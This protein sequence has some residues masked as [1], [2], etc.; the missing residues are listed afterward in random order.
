[1]SVDRDREVGR[2]QVKA[3][4]P[5]LLLD[6]ATRQLVELGLDLIAEVSAQYGT[7]EHPR[8][9]SGTYETQVLMTYHNGGQDGHTSVGEQGCGVPRN[10][11]RLAGAVNAAAKA[12]VISPLVRAIAFYA[13][14]AHDVR[15]L[16]G[17]LLLPEGQQ[18]SDRGDER[19]SALQAQ[20]HL[21]QA[22]VDQRWVDLAQV[23]VLATAYNPRTHNQNLDYGLW[24]PGQPVPDQVA[25]QE[26]VAGADLLSIA[27]R[28]GPTEGVRYAAESLGFHSFGQVAGRWCDQQHLKL[29]AVTAAEVFFR[30]MRPG[31]DLA[32]HFLTFMRG[33]EKYMQTGFRF[34]DRGLHTLCG[35]GIDQL[36]PGRGRNAQWMAVATAALEAG[37]LTPHQVWVKALAHAGLGRGPRR[38]QPVAGHGH[39]ALTPPLAPPGTGRGR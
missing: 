29:G 24:Q 16:C 26:L 2:E 34:S 19:L 6:P 31:T 1:M 7:P 38:P 32:A 13:A 11:L 36:F 25:V 3:S 22:G 28:W 10:V 18:G 33:E 17:R 21:Q 35:K 37:E 30:A 8:W 14:C 39:V 15:Q 27:T 20:H 4:D 12:P 9:A 5:D 23:G